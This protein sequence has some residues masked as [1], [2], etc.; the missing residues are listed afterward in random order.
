MKVHKL[1]QWLSVVLLSQEGTLLDVSAI[2]LVKAWS[3]LRKQ[4]VRANFMH[5]R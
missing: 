1:L 3:F 4:N 5:K 2:R